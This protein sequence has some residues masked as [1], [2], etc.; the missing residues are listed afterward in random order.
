VKLARRA[1][2]RGNG[3]TGSSDIDEGND[4][5][6]APPVLASMPI[7]GPSSSFLRG[8]PSLSTRQRPSSGLRSTGS[9]GMPSSFARAALKS[10]RFWAPWAARARRLGASFCHC[11]SHQR[12][13]CAYFGAA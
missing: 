11:A 8:L 13:A 6:A 4:W 9:G 2:R 3:A 5:Q 7:G 1:R 12:R 10:A